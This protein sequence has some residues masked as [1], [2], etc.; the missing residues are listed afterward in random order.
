MCDFK[1][2]L[3]IFTC[4]C[5]SLLYAGLVY[6]AGCICHGV[7]LSVRADCPDEPISNSPSYQLFFD[8]DICASVCNICHAKSV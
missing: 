2:T 5:C 1:K 6:F 4:R 8:V 3:L 7:C